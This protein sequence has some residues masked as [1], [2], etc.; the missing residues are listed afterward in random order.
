MRPSILK[1]KPLRLLLGAGVI[2]LV[3]VAVFVVRGQIALS[4]GRKLFEAEIWPQARQELAKYLRVFGGDDE[5]RMMM[6]EAYVFDSE[7]AT[8]DATKRAII[9]LQKIP[10]DSKL[11]GDAR[12][13]EARLTFLI[14]QKPHRAELLTRQ[15]IEQNAN[16]LFAQQ[17]LLT[18]LNMTGRH[19]LSEDVFWRVYEL[20]DPDERPLRLREWYMSQFFPGAANEEL[21]RMMNILAPGERSTPTTISRRYVRFREREPRSP[22][23]HAALAQWCQQ[24][25]DPDFGKTLVDAAAKEL[26]ESQESPFFLATQISVYLDLGE[27]EKAQECLEHWPKDDRSQPYWLWKGVIAQDA[28]GKPDKAM[29]AYD[30][31]LAMWPSHMDWR[32]RHRRA[33]CLARLNRSDEAEAERKRAKS[34]QDLLKPDLHRVIRDSL[35]YLGDAEKLKVVVEF[36]DR[37]GR[38]READCWREHVARL[39]EP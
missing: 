13:R 36:Y 30:K 11:A 6:A 28:E 19:E 7:L 24:E 12:L 33:E 15:A 39:T 1:R 18:I 10:P 34:T 35:G 23:T 17:L 31:A 29:E 9:H 3:V 21:D 2:V 4:Q 22:I 20:S 14:I 37:L 8:D 5:A 27:I 32:L 25:G 38:K 26:K 16:E